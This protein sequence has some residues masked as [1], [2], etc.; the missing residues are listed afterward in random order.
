M[1]HIKYA[2]RARVLR[3]R[4]REFFMCWC[5]ERV[6]VDDLE[7]IGRSCGG[8]GMLECLCGGDFCVC[9]NHGE[10]ECGGCEDCGDCD[11]DFWDPDDRY[12][13]DYEDQ[14]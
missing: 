4:G 12:D 8:T 6:A 13:S 14:P 1:S 2:G 5:G 9:H 10:V 7:P 11:D 3:D